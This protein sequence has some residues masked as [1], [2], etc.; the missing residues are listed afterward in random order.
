METSEQAPKA[1]HWLILFTCWNIE[2]GPHAAL[3]QGLVTKTSL[4]WMSTL[5]VREACA[6]LNI[7]IYLFPRRYSTMV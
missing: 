7:M 4:S 3:H 5:R 2:S 1:R 6:Q